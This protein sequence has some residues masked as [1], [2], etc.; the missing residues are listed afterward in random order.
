MRYSVVAIVDVAVVNPSQQ[1]SAHCTD[2][3]PEA[4]AFVFITLPV[5]AGVEVDVEPVRNPVA[6]TRQGQATT[7]ASGE[8][9]P[10]LGIHLG[11]GGS[12]MVASGVGEGGEDFFGGGLRAQKEA[13]AERPRTLDQQDLMRDIRVESRRQELQEILLHFH[14]SLLDGLQAKA[15]VRVLLEAATQAVTLGFELRDTTLE[16]LHHALVGLVPEGGLGDTGSAEFF[17]ELEQGGGVLVAVVPCQQIGAATGARSTPTA[18]DEVVDLRPAVVAGELLAG[19]GVDGVGVDAQHARERE[20]GED[21]AHHGVH[22][23]SPL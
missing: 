12:T 2:T 9:A 14:G 16:G 18:V 22:R 13:G 19:G 4:D 21:D 6:D 10:R 8:I 20:G 11:G 23:H 7:S 15:D 17:G 3:A 1:D 5:L